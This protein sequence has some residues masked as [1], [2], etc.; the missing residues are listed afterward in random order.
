MAEKSKSKRV[1]FPK[2]EQRRF[3]TTAIRKLGSVDA[4]AKSVKLSSRTIR[5]WRREKF[6]MDLVALRKICRA[7]EIEIP[8]NIDIK[9]RYWYVYSGSKAGGCALYKKYGR[10][11]GDPEKR[12]EKWIQW[13]DAKGRFI[14]RHI[15]HRKLIVKPGKSV[16]LAE[17]AG[18]LMGDGGI[19]DR[20]VTITLHDTDDKEYSKF[21]IKLA[22]KIFGVKPSVYHSSKDSVNDIVISRTELVKFLTEKVGLPKGNKV[23]QQFDIPAWI[24]GDRK[25]RVACVRGLF[26]TDGSVFTHRYKVNGKL[27]KYKKLSFTSLSRPLIE[28]VHKILQGLG[29]GARVAQNKEVR[30]DSILDVDKYFKLVGSDNPKHLR[31]YKSRV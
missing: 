1:F 21:V 6:S 14:H 28:S 17:F 13:W 18:I 31:R 27:Y 30:I 29:I 16:E 20:Q 7:I 26:D 9:E 4:L 10:V 15:F 3:I 23:K 19:S 11:G 2:R 25:F 24:K 5:D 8:S 12:K 22:E